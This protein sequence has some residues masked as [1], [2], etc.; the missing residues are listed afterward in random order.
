M[1][2]KESVVR[3]SVKKRKVRKINEI[4]R[5]DKRLNVYTLAEANPLISTIFAF[6]MLLVK[7]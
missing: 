7:R 3:I 5:G 6:I 2:G 4:L 1:I